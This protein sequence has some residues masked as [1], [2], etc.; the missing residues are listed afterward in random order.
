MASKRRAAER[1][2]FTMFNVAYEDGMMTSNRR[3]SNY[4]LNRSFGDVL[5]D[6]AR[7]AIEKQDREIAQLS[8][9]RRAG[10]KS[11]VKV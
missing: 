2:A 9:R 11:I 3:V 10:I 5:L 7:T 6:L 1:A 4:Q 8:G